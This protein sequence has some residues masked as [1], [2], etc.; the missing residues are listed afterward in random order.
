VIRIY[1]IQGRLVRRLDLDPREA[2][3]YLG[4]SQAASWDG[5]NSAG[6]KVASGTYFY[7]IKAGAFSAQR[8]MVVLK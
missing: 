6:E 3:F 1:D 5:R 7:P 8:K 2:G 4:C